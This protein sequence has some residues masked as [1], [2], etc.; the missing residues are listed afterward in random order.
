MRPSSLGGYLPSFSRYHLFSLYVGWRGE[1]WRKRREGGGEREGESLAKATAF[2]AE[3][4]AHSPVTLVSFLSTYLGSQDANH[5]PKASQTIF[6]PW[7]ESNM[8]SPFGTK[9]L[10]SVSVT[11]HRRE[12]TGLM[13]FCPPL[14]LNCREKPSSWTMGQ[15]WG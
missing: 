5:I 7:M 3:L 13:L 6:P 2:V 14:L 12:S 11:F 8:C 10:S 1:G 9:C 15:G 4:L